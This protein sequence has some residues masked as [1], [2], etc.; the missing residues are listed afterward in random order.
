MAIES[1]IADRYARHIILKG[2]GGVGQQKISAARALVIGAGGLGSPVIAYLAGAGVGTLGI[3]DPDSVSISNLQRQII[4]R[5]GDGAIEKTRSA[6]RFAKDLNPAVE[7]IRHQSLIDADSVSQIVGGYDVVIEGTDSFATKRLV[8][9]ACEAAG[10]PL[11]IGALGPFD[12]T[13]TVLAPFQDN[14][15]RFGDLYPNDPSLEES[16]PCELA[17]VLNV[18]PGI[19]GTMMANEA[20]KLIAGYGA[21]LIGKLLVYSARSG[22]TTI[23]RYSRA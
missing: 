7:I 4:H 6:E 13:L 15:P 12:G 16:P 8:A 2:I 1:G 19:I 3:A 23:L 18:L 22:E 5:T 14:N 11:V 21:P 20:L 10:V 9:E 17:G